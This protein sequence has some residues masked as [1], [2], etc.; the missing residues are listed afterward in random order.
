[1]PT[2]VCIG[3]EDPVFIATEVMMRELPD[4]RYLTFKNTGHGIPALRP[5]SYAR[6]VQRFF[7]SLEGEGTVAEKRSVG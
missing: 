5:D 1:M 3:D 6:E 2:L 7:D 4:S